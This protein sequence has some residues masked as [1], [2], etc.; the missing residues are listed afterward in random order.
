MFNSHNSIHLTLNR[1]KKRLCI[2]ASMPNSLHCFLPL[3]LVPYTFCLGIKNLY[4]MPH[5]LCLKILF[6]ISLI[7]ITTN[8]ARAGTQTL[9]LK[10]G[11]NLVSFAVEPTNKAVATVFDPIIQS[12]QFESVWTFDAVTEEWSTYP[13]VIPGVAPITEVAVGKGYWVKVT[14]SVSLE[15]SGTEIPSGDLELTTGWNLVGFPLEKTTDYRY[16]LSGVAISQI[17]TYDANAGIFKGIEFA[18]GTTTTT[19]EE[20]TEI[21]P[22]QAYWVYSN[23]VITLG[24][25]LSTSMEAD[26]DF[27]PFLSTDSPNDRVVWS[28]FTLGDENIGAMGEDPDTSPD[29]YFDSPTT[30]R[31]ITFRD[32]LESQLIYVTNIGSGALSYTAEIINPDASPWV[33]FQVW[34]EEQEKDIKTISSSG[35]VS[36]ETKQLKLVADRTQMAPGDYTAKIRISSNGKA[37]REPTRDIKVH[38]QVASLEGDYKLVASIDTVNGKKADMHNPR[39]YLS[40]YKDTNDPLVSDIKGIIDERRS[41]LMPARF[42][43][44]GQYY[45]ASSNRFS[46][47]GSLVLPGRDASADELGEDPGLNPYQVDLKRDITLLGDRSAAGDS[48]LGPLDLKGE[49]RETIR[50]VLE[51]P[52]YLAGTFVAYRLD[53]KPATLDSLNAY[54]YGELIPDGTG[55]IERIIKVN[56]AKRVLITEVDITPNIDH[57]RPSDLIVSLT[58]PNGTQVI[59]RQNSNDAVGEVTYDENALPLESMDAFIGEDSS[60]DWLLRIQDTVPGESGSLVGCNLSIKGTRIFKVSGRI[61]NVGKGATILLSGCGVS[62]MTITGEDGTFSFD[63]LINCTYS[64]TVIQA[65][66]EQVTLEFTVDSEDL[67]GLTLDPTKIVTPEPGFI[68]GP[69]AGNVPLSVE[70]VDTTDLASGPRYSYDWRIY[71]MDA[72][73]Y[74]DLTADHGPVVRHLFTTPG[75]YQV[76]MSIYDTASP[77]TPLYQVRKSENITVGM[78]VNA[79]Y[80]IL[81]YT[82]YG[83]GGID[84]DGESDREHT[85]FDSATFD[86]DRLPLAANITDT[87]G[88]EDTEAFG[89]VE[90]PLTKTNQIILDAEDRP[91]GD[92]K[93]DPPVGDNSM[94][95]Y[96][97]IGMGMP[98]IGTSVSGQLRLH[99]GPNP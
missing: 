77:G 15:V 42:Y 37:D 75:I 2:G 52:I 33:R 4:R 11:W 51:D 39:Y 95:I 46:V 83:S 99:I 76:R 89:A 68:M 41:L 88:D 17:W 79:G 49:Y 71:D 25:V 53:R 30:Q 98:V 92:G 69:L 13:T 1:F 65:G 70:F 5:T 23:Q 8:P 3:C 6:L 94:R 54:I 28:E 58:S 82:V 35:T 26:K 74:H 80:R 66:Y 40:L 7:T 90:D 38:L 22:G 96:V 14:G 55:D 86:V 27:A 57:P 64:I 50:N 12:G 61:A 32:N 81:S 20:F 18:A 91:I 47:S 93:F 72:G 36:I 45:E 24:P 34:D 73:T 9:E 85:I 84:G 59:L 87:S 44:T 31:A 43:L 56:P 78:P 48:G 29:I 67:E 21:N 10:T 97:N 62:M 63:N 60:S 16:L 19:K